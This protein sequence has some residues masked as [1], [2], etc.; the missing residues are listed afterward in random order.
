MKVFNGTPHAIT[1][2][3]PSCFT[4]KA[5]IRKLVSETPVT[6]ATYL[7]N[8]MLS[9]KF[10]EKTIDLGLGIKTVQKSIV[11]VDPLPDGYDFYI[12]SALYAMAAASTGI[13]TTKLLTVSNPIFTPDGRTVLG[14]EGL[15][16][17]KITS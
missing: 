4:M 15:M 11:S 7:S 1:I 9:A 8:G 5:E 2:L 6:S 3:D 10:E 13:D 12:V 16:V 14:C 17:S